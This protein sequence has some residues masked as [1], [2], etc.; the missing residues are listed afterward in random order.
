MKNNKLNIIALLTLFLGLVSCVEDGD[1]TLPSTEINEPNIKAN[2]TIKAVKEALKQ[3]FNSNNKLV[4]TFPTPDAPN[5]APLAVIEGYVVSSDATGNFYKKL[6]I[7]DKP[8]EPTHGIEILLDN[9]SL[10]QSYEAGRKVYV[11][12]DGLTVTYDDGERTIAFDNDVPGKFTLGQLIGDRVDEVIQPRVAKHVFASATKETIVPTLI[13]VADI[14]EDHINTFIKIEGAQFEKG[15]LVKTFSGEANDSFDGLR[16]FTECASGL[17]M[18][19]Q[20]STFASFKSNIVP[21][22]RGDMM[23]VLTKDFR[24]ENLVAIV[25]TPDALQFDGQRC[26]PVFGEDFQT[27]EDNT[28]LNIDG[29]INIAEVG[30]EL[31]SEQEFR[32]NGYAEFSGFRTGDASNIGWLISPAIDM[33]AQDGEVLTFKAAQHHVSDSDNNTLEVLVSTNFDGTNVATATWT[34]LTATLPT[35]DSSWYAF[36]GSG[37]IDLS[38]YTGKLHIAFKSVASGTDTDL[39]GSYMIDDVKVFVK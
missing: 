21:Q 34:K 20:T 5:A 17:G 14:K 7:Q 35:K 37:E 11:V 30:G 26:D 15:E 8:S 28:D 36:Q 33:D 22:G 38:S 3:E 25:N 1:F 39:D 27:A 32:G 18:N 12:L 16:A 23:F 13:S 4:Y 29:W 19:L 2:S 31:W 9:T 10:S 24:A 6:T